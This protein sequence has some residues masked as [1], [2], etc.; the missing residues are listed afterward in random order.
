MTHQKVTHLEPLLLPALL[1][2]CSQ[3]RGYIVDGIFWSVRRGNVGMLRLFILYRN[4]YIYIHTHQ[5]LRGLKIEILTCSLTN[6][7]PQNIIGTVFELW[8]PFQTSKAH[9]YESI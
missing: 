3:S 4:I 1:V 8:T 5:Q 6:F 9:D 7:K 2:Y